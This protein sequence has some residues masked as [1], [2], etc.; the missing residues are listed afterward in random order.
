MLDLT[1]KYLPS[2][3]TV[4]GKVFS[5]FTDYRLWMKFCIDF[6]NDVSIENINVSYLFKNE[7]PKILDKGFFDFAYPKN[8]LP[9]S[10]NSKSIKLLDYKYDMDIIYSSFMTQYGID[11]IDIEELH[12]FKFNALLG[13]LTANTKLVEVM[14]YRGYEGK[15]KEYIKF[16]DMWEI[17]IQISKEEQKKIDDFEALFN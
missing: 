1:K 15:E 10:E 9:R 8:K 13:G 5:I 4:G 17:P 12:W 14:G 16:R 7:V 2:T 11:I 6:E 3:V